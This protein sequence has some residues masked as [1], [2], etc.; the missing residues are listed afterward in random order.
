[1]DY[2]VILLFQVLFTPLKIKGI[3]YKIINNEIH[4]TE[5]EKDTLVLILRKCI[6]YSYSFFNKKILYHFL[7]FYLFLNIIGFNA[8]FFNKLYNYMLF[9]LYKQSYFINYKYIEKGLFE[10][11][12]VIYNE[13]FVKLIINN[14]FSYFF[15]YY[16][17]IFNIFICIIVIIYYIYVIFH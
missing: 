14:K 17:Y 13:K 11:I 10:I 2:Y 15:L 9:Y 4:F 16:I 12:F 5:T 6:Y 3:L 1:M 8:F 7:N